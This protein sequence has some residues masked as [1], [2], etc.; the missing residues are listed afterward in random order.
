MTVVSRTRRRVSPPVAVIAAGLL[1]CLAAGSAGAVGERSG[2]SA[3]RDDRVTGARPFAPRG[4]LAPAAFAVPGRAVMAAVDASSGP[5][6]GPSGEPAASAA[7][8]APTASASPVEEGGGD[9]EGDEGR[10]KTTASGPGF[11]AVLA[12]VLAVIGFR[13]F[14]RRRRAADESG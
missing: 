8:V 4:P 5:A 1:V 3:A 7:S 6:A 13:R 9:Q 10:P 12:L 2:P 11:L 14:R